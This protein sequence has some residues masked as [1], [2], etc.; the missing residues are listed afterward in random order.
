M[1]RQILLLGASGGVG[2]EVLSQAA[3]AGHHVTAVIRPTSTLRAPEGARVERAE[4]LQPGVLDALVPGHDV[5]ISCLGQRRRSLFPYSRLLSP[6][7]LMEQA[8]DRMIAAMQRAS[9]HRVLVTSAAGVGDSAATMNGLMR[10]LVHTS[11]IGTAYRDLDVMEQRLSASA[12]D[13]TALRPVALSNG[14][15]TGRADVV[16]AFGLR[17]WISRADVADWILR[18]LD[19]CDVRTPLIG[20]P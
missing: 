4:V 13:W 15:R 14:A 11:T 8:A 1:T 12:L 19:G 3:Q 18:H 9:V 20:I 16:Q 2:S 6:P 5:V 7:T 10:F 17:S